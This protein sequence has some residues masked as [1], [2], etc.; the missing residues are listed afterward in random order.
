MNIIIA[1]FMGSGKTT[2]GKAIAEKLSMKF[3]DTDDLIE[4]NENLSV[5]EIFEKFGE[6]YFR[7]LEKEVVEDLKRVNNCVISTGG[8]TLLFRRNLNSLLRKG[9]LITLIVDPEILWERLKS[10][11]KRPLIKGITKE[12]FFNLYNKRASGLENFPNKIDISNLSEKDSAERVLR[13][14][15]GERGDIE[16]KVGEKVSK[17]FFKRFIFKNL[18]EIIAEQDGKI[19]LICD[20]RV[21]KIYREYLKN[22]TSNYSFIH[23]KDRNKNL[24][25]VEKIWKWLL[26]EKIKRDSLI[27]SI[28]GGVTGD[29]CGFVSSTILRG[30]THYHIPSTILSMLDSSIGGKNGIN[31]DSIK[32]AIGTISPPEKVFI[33]PL[34]LSTVPLKEIS[35]GIVEALKAGLIG[36]PEILPLIEERFPLIRMIDIETIEEILFRAIKVKKHIVERD[37]YEKNIRKFLNLGHTLAHAIESY[38]KYKISHGEAVGIGLIYSLKISEDLSICPTGLK[39]R[40]KNILHKLGLKTSIE[41]RRDALMEKIKIDKKSTEKG[42][43]FVLLKEVGKPLLMRNLSEKIMF[44][45]LKEVI[46]ENFIDQWSQSEPYWQKESKG[47]RRKIN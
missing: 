28:G 3:I 35:A 11:R 20:E 19:F 7:N 25:N 13:F 14:L 38:Q 1:G 34:L 30:V 36:D 6:K 17:I 8:K 5:S 18:E 21:F 29:I 9:I 12:D 16:V 47:I 40:V 27:L 10:D 23:G 33:D 37:P 43:D 44:D 41:G 22:I 45:S 42:I 32:N 31:F 2:I 46:H 39:E 4:K 24:R 15:T 26:K